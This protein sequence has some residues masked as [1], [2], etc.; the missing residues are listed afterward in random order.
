MLTLFIVLFELVIT[1][2]CIRKWLKDN[3]FIK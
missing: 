2:A 1:F 3:G